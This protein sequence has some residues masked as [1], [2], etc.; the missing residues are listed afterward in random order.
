MRTI[1]DHPDLD[2]PR[3]VYADWLDEQGDPKLALLAEFIRVEIEYENSPHPSEQASALWD[4]RQELWKLAEGAT[5]PPMPKWTR[6]TKKQPR[7]V[8]VYT[9]RG[10]PHSLECTLKQFA[11]GGTVLEYAPITVVD[12]KDYRDLAADAQFAAAALARKELIRVRELS[13]RG[14]VGDDAFAALAANPHVSN[15]RKIGFS[16]LASFSDA[17]A[18]ALASAASRFTSLRE[19]SLSFENRH[20]PSSHACD[21]LLRAFDGVRQEVLINNHRLQLPWEELGIFDIYGGY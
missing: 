10:L 11:R 17:S 1:V 19:L 18:E 21:V 12:L 8:Y 15:L 9:R 3:L 14:P 4:R 16:D 2:P 7:V 6:R 13:V 20:S 5:L